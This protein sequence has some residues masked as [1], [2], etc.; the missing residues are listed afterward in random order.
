MYVITGLNEEKE[1]VTDM[2][3]EREGGQSNRESK[4]GEQ[5]DGDGKHEK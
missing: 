3:R 5:N 4:M 2:R 1:K